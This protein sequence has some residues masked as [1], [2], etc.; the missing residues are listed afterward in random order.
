MVCSSLNSFKVCYTFVL[1]VGYENII[2]IVLS[3]LG[4]SVYVPCVVHMFLLALLMLGH[5]WLIYW[6]VRSIVR[7]TENNFVPS[8]FVIC[9]MF[10]FGCFVDFCVIF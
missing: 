2:D 3:G 8:L 9:V 4:I 5:P 6:F 10:L 7:Q 1:V